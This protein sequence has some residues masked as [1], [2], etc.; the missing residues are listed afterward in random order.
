MLGGALM[1]GID[2][3]RSA[4]DRAG[5]TRMNAWRRMHSPPC[6]ERDAL[7]PGS[8]SVKR[9]PSSGRQAEMDASEMAVRN[10]H[11]FGGFRRS[12]AGCFHGSLR[13]WVALEYG[14]NN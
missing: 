10:R 12:A 7:R 14:V 8:A 2:P 4:E 6:L 11:F 5:R 1:C 13:G 3:I 9:T